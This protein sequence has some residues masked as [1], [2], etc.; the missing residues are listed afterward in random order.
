[1]FEVLKM[2][3]IKFFG[4]KNSC[5]IDYSSVSWKIV[6]TMQ[7]KFLNIHDEF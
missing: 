4:M 3:K 6:T 5:F 2:I 7:I 1:M